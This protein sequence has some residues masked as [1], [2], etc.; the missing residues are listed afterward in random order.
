MN[1]QTYITNGNDF[2]ATT[3][4]GVKWIIVKDE[5]AL[6][7]LEKAYLPG[8]NFNQWSSFGLTDKKGDYL[9]MASL[10]DVGDLRGKTIFAITCYNTKLAQRAHELV[11][12]RGNFLTRKLPDAGKLLKEW[13][14]LEKTGIDDGQIIKVLCHR[15][16]VGPVNISTIIQDAMQHETPVEEEP[17]F[18]PPTVVAKG[19]VTLVP[20]TVKPNQ[21]C[22]HAWVWQRV[23]A[24]D[25]PEGEVDV[26]A[27]RYDNS[28]RRFEYGR[29][30]DAKLYIGDP[31]EV[32]IE[33]DNVKWKEWE[34]LWFTVVNLPE[35]GSE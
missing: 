9:I 29:F 3:E 15:Y 21:D 31:N 23:D 26:Y 14:E 13:R 27:R 6:T 20:V 2:N 18:T 8:I 25:L 22:D 35:E 16:N 30:C 10:R 17:T 34:P 4:T 28:K 11:Q 19:T 1:T 7:W 32:L 24:C 33:H 12:E 5:N